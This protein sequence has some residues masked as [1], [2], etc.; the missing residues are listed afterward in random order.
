MLSRIQRPAQRAR[1]SPQVKARRKEENK[2]YCRANGAYY[3]T[4]K[5][6]RYD[7]KNT[8]IFNSS[9][10]RAIDKFVDYDDYQDDPEKEKPQSIIDVMNAAGITD[11]SEV[12]G[13]DVWCAEHFR[14]YGQRCKDVDEDGHILHNKFS[15]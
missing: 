6:I 2:S 9:I 1:K 10:K 11:H 7:Q 4:I 13:R 3:N 15:R 14:K 8:E 12:E 5:R